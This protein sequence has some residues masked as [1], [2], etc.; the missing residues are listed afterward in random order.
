M[1]TASLFC[2]LNADRMA[3]LIRQPVDITIFAIQPNKRRRY[4][5]TIRAVECLDDQQA[6]DTLNAFKTRHWLGTMLDEI[7]LAGGN[8]ASA[9]VW[10]EF[11]G[12]A[13]D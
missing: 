7:A 4:V 8:A 2:A 11:E 10:K 9:T 6:E 5:A 12:K 1:A 3:A 13:E